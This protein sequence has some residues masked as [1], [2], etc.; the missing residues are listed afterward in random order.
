MGS[1]REFP[2]LGEPYFG[3]LIIRILL[4]RGTILR[5]PLFSETPIR[6][7]FGDLEGSCKGSLIRGSIKGLGVL[8]RVCRRRSIPNGSQVP[9]L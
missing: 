6:V 5:V 8:I 4:F 7:P 2:K 3:V 9:I 1:I